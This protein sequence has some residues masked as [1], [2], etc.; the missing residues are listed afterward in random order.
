MTVEN[1]RVIRLTLAIVLLPILKM[2]SDLLIHDYRIITLMSFAL[3]NVIAL[4]LAFNGKSTTLSLLV[5]IAYFILVTANAFFSSNP[6][7][8]EIFSSVAKFLYWGVMLEYLRKNNLSRDAVCKLVKIISIFFASTTLISVIQVIPSAPLHNLFVSYGGNITSGTILGNIRANGGI[9]GTAIDYSFFI[10]FTFVLYC[11]A[12]QMLSKRLSIIVLI[13]VIASTFLNYSRATFVGLGITFIFYFLLFHKDIKWYL[14][15]LCIAGVLVFLYLL[16]SGRNALLNYMFEKDSYRTRSDSV[17][18]G[19]MAEGL[20]QISS[21]FQLLLGVRLG[22]NT[23]FSTNK[24][25]GDGA[26]VS[27]LLDYGLIGL[28]LIYSL[29][30]RAILSKR[31]IH[32]WEETFFLIISFV[33]F[34]FETFINS[35]FFGNVN[36]L[37]LPI[38]YIIMTSSRRDTSTN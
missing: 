26:L 13:C 37:L 33:V 32:S 23:G 3:C 35:G 28:I 12:S 21:P 36:I 2:V 30:V 8:T 5:Y 10:V 11:Y 24:I 27:V 18:F 22:A 16:S 29:P 14:K 38:I 15:I 17:R 34:L 20:Q 7:L 31:K 9:G 6:D 1:K 19:Q 4:L 25:I